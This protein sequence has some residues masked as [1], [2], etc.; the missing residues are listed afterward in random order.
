MTTNNGDEPIIRPAT[1]DEQRAALIAEVRRQVAAGAGHECGEWIKDG[2][3]E[4]CDRDFGA[5]VD[6]IYADMSV[7]ILRDLR[8]AF[9]ADKTNGADAGFCDSRIAAIDAEL[10]TRGES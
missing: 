10:K 4:L 1:L 8:A 7:K 6:R 5:G 9:E 3:C 2:R